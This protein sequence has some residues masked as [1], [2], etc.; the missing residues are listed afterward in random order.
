VTDDKLNNT[1]SIC[2]IADGTQKS[3]FEPQKLLPR[4]VRYGSQKNSCHEWLDMGAKK[5]RLIML[6]KNKPHC[7]GLDQAVT[8]IN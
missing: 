1:F 7:L 2:P 8:N 6:A 4:M 5:F 3:G